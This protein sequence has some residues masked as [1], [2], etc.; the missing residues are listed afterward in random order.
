MKC[1]T[2]GNFVFKPDYQHLNPNASDYMFPKTF[3]IKPNKLC[4][5]SNYIR[6]KY[7]LG[8]LSLCQ[9]TP[10]YRTLTV[11]GWMVITS[12]LHLLHSGLHHRGA[13]FLPYVR[14]LCELVVLNFDIIPYHLACCNPI[15]LLVIGVNRLTRLPLLN[16]V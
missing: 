6:K 9:L 14:K 2:V 1:N 3:K 13:I 4:K 12:T 16:N 8:Q 10:M 7:K 5:N 15:E 11:E